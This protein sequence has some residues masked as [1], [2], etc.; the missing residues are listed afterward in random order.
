[1][2]FKR[3]FSL[4]LSTL[5][6]GCLSKEGIDPATTDQWTYLTKKKGLSEDFVTA[7]CEDG[8]GVF[9]F[10]NNNTG[11]TSYDGSKFTTVTS[12]DGLLS[13]T[14]NCML[15]D[16]DSTLMVGTTNGLN[17]RLKNDKIWRYYTLL[18]NIPIQSIIQDKKGIHWIGTTG[19]GIIYLKDQAFYQVLDD[20]CA[21][22]NFINSILEASDGK[23]WFATA[24][25][26]KFFDGISYTLFSVDQFKLPGKVIYS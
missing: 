12:T 20:N 18:A 4:L 17:V 10:G 1:M 24:G 22:C 9:W 21:D 25:G 26:V 2:K 19:Y 7:I 13:N 14:V 15:Y 16:S 5:I 3:I 11:L 8:Q 23:I 6:F